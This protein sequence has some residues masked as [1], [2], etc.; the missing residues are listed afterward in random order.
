MK[1]K[2][3]SEITVWQ[4]AHQLTLTV[5]KITQKFPRE[6][7]FRLAD[8]VCRANASIG[9]N[10]VEGNEKYSKKDKANFLVTAKASAVEVE[11]HLFLAKDLQYISESEF[12]KL[13][14]EIQSIAAQLGGWI[15][16]LL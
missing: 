2:H 12:K 15:K 5:Y 13:E 11:Q 8:Q 6:E 14:K 7:R 1:Y 16:A 10:I 3:F 4:N 9:A